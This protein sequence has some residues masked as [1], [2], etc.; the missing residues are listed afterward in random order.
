M[1]QSVY[2]YLLFKDLARSSVEKYRVVHLV[3]DNLLLNSNWELCFSIRIYT[4]TE[5]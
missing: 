1:R 5:L 2:L 3:A 4:V